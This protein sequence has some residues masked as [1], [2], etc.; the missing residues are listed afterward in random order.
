MKTTIDLQTGKVFHYN[1]VVRFAG[2]NA[3]CL[4]TKTQCVELHPDRVPRR[5]LEQLNPTEDEEACVC[6]VCGK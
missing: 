4:M 5:L 6:P 1:T 3:P 2:R